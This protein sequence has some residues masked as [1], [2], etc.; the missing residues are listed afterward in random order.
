MQTSILL[1]HQVSFWW[2]WSWSGGKKRKS[3]KKLFIYLQHD[4]SPKHSQQVTAPMSVF[5]SNWIQLTTNVKHIFF[6]NAWKWEEATKSRWRRKKKQQA[7]NTERN[8]KCS[9]GLQIKEEKRI[10]KLSSVVFSVCFACVCNSLWVL[11]VVFSLCFSVWM[12]C[13]NCSASSGWGC[14]S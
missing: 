6:K 14:H 5:W 3:S 12:C 13:L 8:N 11:A 10:K 2:I 4:L 7:A 1:W 9:N